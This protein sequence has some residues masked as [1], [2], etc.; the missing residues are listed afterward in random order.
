MTAPLIT[1]LIDTYNYGRFIE[2]AIH[3][4]FDQDFPKEQLEIIVVDDGSTD[5]TA[6]RVKQYGSRVQYF[7]KPNGGQASAFNLG[8]QKARGE[9][10]ALLDADDYWLPSKVRRVVEQ[11]DSRPDAGLVYH[12]FREFK[13]EASEW[14]D[15][16]F[17]AV[18]GFA[19]ADEIKILTWFIRSMTTAT[20]PGEGVGV[21]RRG[22]GGKSGLLRRAAPYVYD[23][24]RDTCHDARRR[25]PKGVLA[26][27]GSRD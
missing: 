25:D 14:R 18:S 17:N 9:L 5:D 7:Y 23:S 13:T 2:E 20:W 27:R 1:V 6:E 26:E 15:G 16:G 19:P 3:S 12:S 8:L 24:E 10:V 21:W 22:G 4:V 11:F